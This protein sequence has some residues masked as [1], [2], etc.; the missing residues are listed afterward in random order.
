MKR[1]HGCTVHHHRYMEFKKNEFLHSLH[2][3][4]ILEA[5]EHYF[6]PDNFLSE[7]DRALYMRLVTNIPLSENSLIKLLKVGFSKDNGITHSEILELIDQ[8]IQRAAVNSSDIFPMLDIKRLDIFELVFNL[9]SY[10]PP[11][12]INIPAG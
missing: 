5:P 12:S 8:L 11:A 2:K 9:C 1:Y 6:K 10:Q 4:M 3:I 7:T